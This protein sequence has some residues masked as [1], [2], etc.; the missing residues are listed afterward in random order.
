MAHPKPNARN[1][2]AIRSCQG[3]GHAENILE[4]NTSAMIAVAPIC[5]AIMDQNVQWSNRAGVVVRGVVAVII[6]PL[7]ASSPAG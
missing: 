7:P 5:A 3:S 1:V 2:A 4:A 6:A